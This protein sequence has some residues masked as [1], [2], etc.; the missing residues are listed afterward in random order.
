VTREDV[1]RRQRLLHEVNDAIA[2]ISGGWEQTESGFLCECGQTGCT[3][4]I[5]LELTEFEAL[6]ATEGRFIV[7]RGHVI[8]GIDRLE[9]SRDGYDVVRMIA[10]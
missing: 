5:T 8:A 1:R 7:S 2:D 10:V 3:E 4:R 9:E 6:H